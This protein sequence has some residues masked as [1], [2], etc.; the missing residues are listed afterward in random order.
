MT[1]HDG[2]KLLIVK[3]MNVR[4]GYSIRK[5]QIVFARGTSG[6]E[7]KPDHLPIYYRDDTGMLRMG[8]VLADE[9]E[10]IE[11]KYIPLYRLLYD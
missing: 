3:V 7:G 9:Y 11:L 1:I 5:G 10:L 2:D 4:S 6:S 8:Q